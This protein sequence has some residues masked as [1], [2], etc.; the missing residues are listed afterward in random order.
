MTDSE[1]QPRDGEAIGVI[2]KALQPL[3][4]ASREKVLAAVCAYFRPSSPIPSQDQLRGLTPPQGAKEPPP[5]VGK[6]DIRSFKEEKSPRTDIEMAAVM[7][8]YLKEMAPPEDRK[9]G[10]TAEDVEK[11]FKQAGHRLPKS[12]GQ[13]L[14]NARNAGY[15]DSPA[16]GEF[17][18]NAVG[19]NLVAHSLPRASAETKPK[20]KKKA[21]SAKKG[22]AGGK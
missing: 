13:T 12:L 8:Y 1:G 16:E 20:R 17:R 11:Y 3:N 14:R 15:F 10:V 9:E 5:P 22:K 21:S 18:L 6:R 19:H 4:D 2:L 7:A